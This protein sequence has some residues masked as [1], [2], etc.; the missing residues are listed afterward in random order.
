MDTIWLLLNGE[1]N[2]RGKTRSMRQLNFLFKANYL[3]A[4]VQ[5]KYLQYACHMNIAPLAGPILKLWEIRRR[6]EVLGVQLVTD[7]SLGSNDNM[8]Y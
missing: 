5:Q 7:E 8:T 1:I 3:A 2:S 4:V 6:C